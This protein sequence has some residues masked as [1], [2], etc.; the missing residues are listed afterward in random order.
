MIFVNWR[1]EGGERLTKRLANAPDEVRE[2]I[3]MTLEFLGGELQARMMG[4]ERS[5]LQK[6]S[7]KLER[8]FFHKVINRKDKMELI[9][10]VR[11]RAFYAAFQELGVSATA[12]DV[13]RWRTKFGHKEKSKVKGRTVHLDPRPFIRPAYEAMRAEIIE[14]LAM[15]VK[16][17]VDIA[18]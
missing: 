15:A 8:S 4:L 17:G 6:R 10:G 18:P 16:R 5:L 13:R 11:V 3:L 7:G 1:Q 9:T 2:R 14:N 12:G